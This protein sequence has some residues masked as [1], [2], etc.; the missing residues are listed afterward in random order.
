MTREEDKA[1]NRSHWDAMA[2][3][4]KA[5]WPRYRPASQAV[6]DWLVQR[7]AVETG[8]RVL[9]LAT[10]LGEPALSFARAVGPRGYVLGVDQSQEMIRFASEQAQAEGFNNTR[11]ILQDVE[12]LDLPAE[13]PFDVLVSRWGLMFS[14]EPVAMLQQLKPWLK[15]SGR[16]VAAVWSRAQQVPMLNLASEVLKD[17]L[18]IDLSRPGPGPFTLSDPEYLIQLLN[19]AGFELEALEAVDVVLDYSSAA[20][21]LQD[22]IQ[23][24]LLLEAGLQELSTAQR[25]AYEQALAE[26]IKPWQQADQIALVNKAL[27]FSCRLA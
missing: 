8:Q 14:T 12:A 25:Q 13:A 9:D 20:E 2:P 1:H 4:W 15:P 7:S 11:F 17:S 26:A 24:S 19:Q 3:R 18:G 6:S 23:T 10:G 16:L 22:R 21:Y 27:C 5:W